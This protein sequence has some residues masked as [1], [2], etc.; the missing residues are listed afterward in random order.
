MTSF[1]I[2]TLFV[3]ATITTIVVAVVFVVRRLTPPR[4][5]HDWDLRVTLYKK[6]LVPKAIQASYYSRADYLMILE[7]HEALMHGETRTL[8]SCKVCG[9]LRERVYPGIVTEPDLSRKESLG[10]E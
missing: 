2:G 5:K 8:F 9:L 6:P 3:S 1:I 4:C 7:K 10:R